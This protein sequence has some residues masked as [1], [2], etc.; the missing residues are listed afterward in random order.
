MDN[1]QD[2][3]FFW[4]VKDFLN[5][6][7]NP[8]QMAPTNSL[9]DAASKV[10]AA[11]IQT[12][13]NEV[14][15][16]S[17]DIQN[18]TNKM[19]NMYSNSVNKQKASSI[20]NSN[21]ITANLFNLSEQMYAPTMSSAGTLRQT[22]KGFYYTP[23]PSTQTDTSSVTQETSGSVSPTQDN[24]TQ[25][26]MPTFTNYRALNLS[27][28]QIKPN[29]AVV[30]VKPQANVE[31]SEEKTKDTQTPSMGSDVNVSINDLMDIA[32]KAEK[33]KTTDP[34]NLSNPLEASSNE[35]IFGHSSGAYK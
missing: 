24:P 11:N 1:K 4:K 33:N 13:V 26:A 3:Q 29:S 2:R 6:S 19:L 5:G 31:S 27:L 28:G 7:S 32:K 15:N 17:S 18:Q 9:K 23:K 16:T 35:I 21:N 14:K 12:A 25:Q 22:R 10:M 30:G 20:R 34:K 8:G